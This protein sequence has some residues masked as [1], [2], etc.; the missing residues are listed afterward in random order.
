[1]LKQSNLSAKLIEPASIL[2]VITAI[3]YFWGHVFFAAFC[4]QLGI[5]FEGIEVPFATYLLVGWQHVFWI[6][7]ILCVVLCWYEQGV[8]LLSKIAK[9][10][11]EE[12]FKRFRSFFEKV[13][14][15]RM[16]NWIEDGEDPPSVLMK[17]GLILLITICCAFYGSKRLVEQGQAFAD[18]QL[19]E[20]KAIVIYDTENQILGGQFIYLMDYG[21]VLI[22]GEQSE[23]D[24]TTGIRVIKE[25]NY[26]A[27]TLTRDVEDEA[28]HE[29]VTKLAQTQE[30]QPQ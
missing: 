8:W 6:T 24:E 12:L 21:S 16:L 19:E 27:Y 15:S 1:M 26:S 23:D 11:L 30:H 10:I 18:K 2:A 28:K 20:K 22:V 29:E 17:F 4:Q 5:S 7:I 13:F 14:N 3:L 25:G 9:S